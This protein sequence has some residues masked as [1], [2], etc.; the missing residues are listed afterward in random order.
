VPTQLGVGRLMFR[1][2]LVANRGEIACRIIRTVSR[3]GIRSV[4]VYSEADANA[5]HV[6]LAEEAYAIG[7]APARE[8]YLRIDRIIE[9][10]RRSGAEAV[11]PGYG[12]LAEN[13]A[14][15]EACGAAG[16]TFIGPDPHAIR[17][18]GSKSAAKA[19]MEK[20]GVPLV[21]GYHGD[22]QDAEFLRA[23]AADIGYPVLLKASA[24]GGGKGMRVVETAADFAEALERA[25]GEARASFGDDRMLVEK[26]LTRPRHIEVQVF[27]DRHGNTVSLFERD[28]S[29]QRRHQKVVEEAPAPGLSPDERRALGETAVAAARAVDYVGAGTVEFIY[30]DGRFYFM[31]MNTRLQVEHPVTEFVTGLDLVEWQLRVAAGEKLPCSDGTPRLDGHAIEVRIC[32]EDPAQDYRPATGTITHLRQPPAASF[33]RIDTG[34]G[35]GDTVTPYYDSMIAKLIVWGQ[36]RAEALR[37]LRGALAAY[38][39]GGL[40]SNLPLLRRIAADDAF[41]AGPVD[42][43]FLGRKPHLAGTPDET[44]PNIWAAAAMFRLARLA[45][46]ADASPWAVTDGWRMNAAPAATIVLRHDG[47]DE[48]IVAMPAGG[49]RWRL[50]FS[51]SVKTASLLPAGTDGDYRLVLGD[52]SIRLRITEDR[53]AISVFHEGAGFVFHLVD[54][55]APP[56]IS[57]TGEDKLV[58]PTPARVAAVFVKAGA[59]VAKGQ[60]LLILEA[61]KVETTFTAPHDGVVDNVLV[62]QDEMIAEG[63]VLVTFQPGAEEG[64]A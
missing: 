22:V 64:G 19:L 38:E 7:P 51:G 5:R 48:Q 18:M 15:A 16:L 42:T 60:K 56:D 43:G 20:S 21:P 35:E 46:A 40:R 3:M 8:S 53:D 2:V 59:H 57:S 50:D 44:P 11:H 25:K 54:R 10:A 4:A 12:F 61:M 6:A 49:Q 1:T 52:Q 17:A 37:R 58:A 26:Y 24:G 62:G 14:F 13:A 34:F 27:A 30:E 63:A 31:E 32:A 28:C 29:I 41:A 36:D 23:R 45:A 47:H 9:A 39:L 33:V 55:L